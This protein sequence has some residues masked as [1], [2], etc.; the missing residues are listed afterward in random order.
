MQ[1]SVPQ[2]SVLVLH[3]REAVGEAVGADVGSGTVQGGCAE[4]GTEGSQGG[5]T[6]RQGGLSQGGMVGSHGGRTVGGR[7]IVGTPGVGD[8]VGRGDWRSGPRCTGAAPTGAWP[9]C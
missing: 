9:G 3:R 6:I 4:G 2:P 7:K 8:L 1:P 5:R